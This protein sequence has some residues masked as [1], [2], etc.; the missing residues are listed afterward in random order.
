MLTLRTFK[1]AVDA[2]WQKAVQSGISGV[3]SFVMGGRKLV[4]AHP[5]DVLAEGLRAAG[6][7]PKSGG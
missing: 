6:A 4:G 1:D 5:Y 2:D 7:R 3:P